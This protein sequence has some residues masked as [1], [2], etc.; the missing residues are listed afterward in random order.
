MTDSYSDRASELWTSAEVAERFRVSAK[1]VGRWVQQGKLRAVK[2]PGGRNLFRA[3]D[4]E[5]WSRGE[6]PTPAAA[7]PAKPHRSAVS[8]Q[9]IERLAKEASEAEELVQ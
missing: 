1:T 3:D 5:R 4:I 2:T 7:P 9:I 6:V 8:R